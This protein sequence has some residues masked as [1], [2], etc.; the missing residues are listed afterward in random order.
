MARDRLPRL[1]RA[2]LDYESF[3]GEVR[4]GLV[5][6]RAV[7]RVVVAV[8]AVVTVA[9]ALV[10]STD[11][12]LGILLA[13]LAPTAAIGLLVETVAWWVGRHAPSSPIDD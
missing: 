10:G 7:F 1:G 12:A 4:A 6:S 13:F 3:S 2:E 5:R 11:A 9:A 8:L